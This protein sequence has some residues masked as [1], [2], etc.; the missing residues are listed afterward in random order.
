MV[1]GRGPVGRRFEWADLGLLAVVS[2]VWGAAFPF[3]RLGLIE[4]AAPLE[5]AAVRYAIAAGVF[6][7]LAGVRREP[8]PPRRATVASALIGGVLIIGLYG[9]FLYWGEQYA[10]G[11]YAAVLA[12]ASPLI[13]VA[14]GYPLLASERL[15]LTGTVGILVGFTG[16]AVLVLPGLAGSSLGGGL[17]VV[18]VL[19]AVVSTATGTVLLRRFGGGPQGLWQ[20]AVQFSVASLLL[21]AGSTLLKARGGLPLN[22][23]TLASLAFLV[24]FSSV[25]GYF[26]YFSLHHRVGPVRANLV[27]YLAPLIGVGTGFALLGEPVTM[28]E[29]GGVVTVLAGVTLALRQRPKT[30]SER[31]GSMDAPR[32]QSD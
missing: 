5:F 31:P 12:S 24:A 28:W 25:I 32:G 18:Y 9:G 6:F 30:A 16:V 14:L 22:T 13:T 27:A 11:G 1:G 7:V 2:I 26:A 29:L 19:A 3:I 17:G 4:G 8:L 15:D 10:D 21:G 23:G 20:L